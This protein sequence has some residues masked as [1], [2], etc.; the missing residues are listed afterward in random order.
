MNPVFEITTA[1]LIVKAMETPYY[2]LKNN[3]GTD[4][5]DRYWVVPYSYEGT[6][7][8]HNTGPLSWRTRPIGRLLQKLD[9]AARVH[10]IKSS[11][12]DRAPHDHPWDYWTIVLRGGYW[13]IVPQYDDSGLYTGDTRIWYGPGSFIRRKANSRH[14]LELP[15]GEDAWTLFITFKK[16]Q[17]WGFYPH[18]NTKISYNDFLGLPP[19]ND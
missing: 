7:S 12:D 19:S 5:M 16:K 13:E 2:H 11:D 6:H 3:D 8:A 15:E 17:K 10:N 18:R 1:A 4:Y 14:I 9:I